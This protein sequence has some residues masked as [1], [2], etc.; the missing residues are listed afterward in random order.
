METTTR[1]TQATFDEIV[2]HEREWARLLWEESSGRV[3]IASS[4]GCWSFCW[5]HIG[6]RSLREFLADLDM[7]Y[8]G[9]KMLGSHSHVFSLEGTVQCIKEWIL[10]YRKDRSFTKQEAREEWDIMLKFKCGWIDFGEWYNETNIDDAYECSQ[11][12][13]APEWRHFW[14]RLWVPLIQPILID[15]PV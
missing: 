14:E 11:N 7:E 12:E 2:V 9:K 8:M 10:R 5:T 15:S 4:Y 13:M 3:F 1:I 6:E